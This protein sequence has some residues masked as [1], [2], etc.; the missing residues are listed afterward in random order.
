MLLLN[1]PWGLLK[2]STCFPLTCSHL[3]SYVWVYFKHWM[4]L[5]FFAQGM[6]LFRYF[7]ASKANYLVCIAHSRFHSHPSA[8]SSGSLLNV[9]KY[10]AAKSCPMCC[11]SLLN[12]LATLSYNERKQKWKQTSNEPAQPI[13]LQHPLGHSE[14]VKLCSSTLVSLGTL[15]THSWALPGNSLVYNTTDLTLGLSAYASSD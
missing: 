1:K 11:S 2:T 15:R 10:P 14:Y 8:S 13:K 3:V 5:V 9:V 12:S 6:R 7:F 4:S